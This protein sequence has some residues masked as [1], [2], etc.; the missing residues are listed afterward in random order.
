MLRCVYS[1]ST[2]KKVVHVESVTI[3]STITKESAIL[4]GSSASLSVNVWSER[5]DIH[6]GK[7]NFD[8]PEHKAPTRTLD[9]RPSVLQRADLKTA[10]HLVVSI[11]A[12]SNRMASGGW[13]CRTALSACSYRRK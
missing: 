13:V 8:E 5:L 1:E 7:Y 3:S 10:I 9:L 2:N 6:N 12:S 4:D 11:D